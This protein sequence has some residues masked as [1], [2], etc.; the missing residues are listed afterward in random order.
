VVSEAYRGQGLSRLLF[1]EVEKIAR[2]KGCCK[3]TLEVV[4]KNHIAQQAYRNFGF[5][6]YE[7]NANHGQTL[8]WDKAL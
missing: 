6:G 8:F 2:Q 5:A 3:L 1:A 4:E 7:L